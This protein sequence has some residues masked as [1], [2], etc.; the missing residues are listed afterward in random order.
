M[1]ILKGFMQGASQRKHADGRTV[2]VAKGTTDSL[3]RYKE[4]VLPRGMK[5]EDFMKN[6][7][8]ID[9]HDYGKDPI[10]TI[11]GFRIAEDGVEYDF[12]F[13]PGPEGKAKEAK[14]KSGTL[15]AFSIGF[16][17]TKWVEQEEMKD[18][19]GKPLSKLSVEDPSGEKYDVDLTRYK[20]QPR[21]M[22]TEWELLELSLVS[23]PANPDALL[24]N[25]VRGLADN[26]DPA[27]AEFV[28]KALG[29]QMESLKKALEQFTKD[30]TE[31][32]LGSVERHPDIEVVTEAWK[33]TQAL[34]E[35][36]QWASNDGSGAKA[37]IDWPK[38]SLGFA[39]FDAETIDN[40]VSYKYIHH[41]VKDG[42][43]VAVKAGVL[44]A[45]AA[46]L[47]ECGDADADGMQKAAYDHLSDHLKKVSAAV[48]EWGKA[49]TEEDLKAIAAGEW[50]SEPNAD[51]TGT[52]DP[53]AASAPPA[54]APPAADGDASFVKAV[55]E[56]NAFLKKIAKGVSEL[57]I[58]SDM[59][60][61]LTASLAGPAAPPQAGSD[62]G[63]TGTGSGSGPDAGSA[64]NNDALKS[65]LDTFVPETK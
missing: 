64:D 4:V 49:Y 51:G 41:T 33:D 57:N 2:Y 38:F 10:G 24:L 8:L 63:A 46:L 15:R 9:G 40:F 12:V 47:G 58:K 55:I 39:K 16:M 26:M 31:A 28:E 42:K 17:P 30:F 45:M 14:V 43:L 34:V 20:T 7:V 50:K 36:A 21:R 44:A 53:A 60:Y 61:D 1:L 25:M 11:L 52:T 3:D 27:R 54:D 18:K 5:S 65:I 6:P 62:K 29:G 56:I 37:T 35:L 23:I 22:F 48:P 19:E 59:L 13:D 32:K